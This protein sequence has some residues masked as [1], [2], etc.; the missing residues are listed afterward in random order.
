MS[1]QKQVSQMLSSRQQRNRKRL[2]ISACVLA[3]AL[4]AAALVQRQRMAAYTAF[5]ANEQVRNRT[6]RPPEAV[7]GTTAPSA[8]S[9]EPATASREPD[10]P[11]TKDTADV[12]NF[13]ERWRSTIARGDI[14]AHVNCYAAKVDRYF[15]QRNVPRSQVLRD[16]KRLFQLWPIFH[17][18]DIS[19]VQVAPAGAGRV[20]VTFRKT[21]DV[22]STSRR[23]AGDEKERLMLAKTAGGWQIVSE[24]EL[25]VYRVSRR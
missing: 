22:R 21:W 8:L 24:E 13:I 16:K 11:Q 6:A 2:I 18:Y 23:F 4:L 25:K 15:R 7:F 10:V 9:R 14:E 19:D 17:R 3:V 20:R 5:A 12:R 1:A